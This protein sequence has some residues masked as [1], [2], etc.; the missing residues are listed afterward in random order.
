MGGERAELSLERV[1]PCGEGMAANLTWR[2]SAHREAFRPPPARAQ[3][4]EGLKC[5]LG[6]WPVSRPLNAEE[7]W[8][9]PPAKPH[10][11][12]F[13]LPAPGSP[14]ATKWGTN[15]AWGL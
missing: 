10:R 1:L 14:L 11:L 15:P 6:S 9:F 8:A 3:E 12:E 2:S 5:G 4:D 7:R 13:V